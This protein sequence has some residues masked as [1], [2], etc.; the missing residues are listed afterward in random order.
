M[1]LGDPDAARTGADDLREVEA[2]PARRRAAR[3]RRPGDAA[4]G[5]DPGA[6]AALRAAGA[7]GDRRAGDR[8]PLQQALAPQLRP[9]QRLLPARL[10]HDE[11][12]PAS[13]RAGGGAARPRPPAPGP[14]PAPRPG[15]AGADV[16]AAALAGGDLRPAA[17]QPAALRR[18]PRR[19][20]RP[21]ADPRLPR[22]PR[23][24]PDQGAGSRHLARDQPGLGDDGRLRGR[25]GRDQRARR[26]RDGRPAGQGSRRAPTRSPA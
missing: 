19:A 26:G 9:R 14:G 20:R 17:R 12:Q 22:R 7:A 21:A 10:L 11:A 25:Q 5:A 16:A 4:G 23:R 15:G 2:G 8:P 13:Q 6:P 18:L 3:H 1:R 24:N